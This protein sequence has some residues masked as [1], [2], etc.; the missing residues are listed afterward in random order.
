M[1]TLLLHSKAQSVLHID[2]V[3]HRE[4]II[5]DH[6]SA[7]WRWL[8]HS[9]VHGGGGIFF[10]IFGRFFFMTPKSHPGV[11]RNRSV[12]PGTTQSW[13]PKSGLKV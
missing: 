5:T 7:K 6:R 11:V 2:L 1:I 8:A 10:V 9:V 4:E 13:C 12:P 3:R